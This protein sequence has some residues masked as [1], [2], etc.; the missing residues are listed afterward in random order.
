MATLNEIAVLVA[1]PLGRAL[2]VPFKEQVKARAKAWRS[3]LLRDTLN[4][5]PKDRVF[6]TQ[7]ITMELEETAA[8]EC[9]IQLPCKVLRTKEKIPTVVR[10]NNIYLDYVGSIDGSNGFRL[11][12]SWQ[13]PFILTA[14][15]APLVSHFYGVLNERVVLHK[16]PLMTH[17][18]VEGIFDDPEAAYLA[19]CVDGACAFEDAEYPIPGDLV[20]QIV[21]YILQVDFNRPPL[22]EP[23]TEVNVDSSSNGKQ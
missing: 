15:Y 9:G 8:T 18:R 19:S 22:D 20:Q 17:V 1:E 13:L 23:K 4:R 5:N 11:T 16:N 12:P 6:F 21:Q 3:K 14:K 7:S 10:A 2:D